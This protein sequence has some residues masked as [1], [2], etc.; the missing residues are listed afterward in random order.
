M[1]PAKP[2]SES[3]KER[4][5]GLLKKA[6]TRADFQRVQCVWLRASLNLSAM[7]VAVAI[8]WKAGSVRQLQSNYLKQGESA[9]IGVGRGGRRNSYLTL[10]EEEDFLRGFIERAS[11]GGILV[12]GEV[13]RAFETKIGRKVPKSTIYRMLARHGWRKVAPRPRHPKS[14]EVV[15][16]TYKKIPIS[17]GNRSQA[18]RRRKKT[19]VDVPR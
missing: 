5:F 17:P 3:S 13:K 1:R 4:L 19:A 2:I 11:Q 6:R 7:D 10:E 14:D 15:Q 18:Q 8:G 16:E 9:L 12:A